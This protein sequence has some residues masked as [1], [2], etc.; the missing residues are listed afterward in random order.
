MYRYLFF[1]AAR[2]KI[3]ILEQLWFLDKHVEQNTRKALPMQYVTWKLTENCDVPALSVQ[4]KSFRTQDLANV[5]KMA[6]ILVV[7]VG[8]PELG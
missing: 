6:D 1:I 2:G 4:S 5:C 8:K 3:P 7:A